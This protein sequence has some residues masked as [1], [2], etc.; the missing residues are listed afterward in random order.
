[1]D[2]IEDVAEQGV[3]LV[4]T[5]IFDA[6]GPGGLNWLLD[7]T[8]DMLV[9]RDDVV[10]AIDSE[11]NRVD[12][13]IK[14]GKPR[15]AIELPVDFDLGL[16][17]LNFEL[18]APVDL[19]FGFAF[20]LGFGVGVNEGF[21]L[22]VQDTGILVDF[23]AAVEDLNA[24]GELAF[25]NVD[26]TS[27]IDQQT[28]LPETRFTGQFE[29]GLVDPNSDNRLTLSEMLG[30][31]PSELIETTFSA[32]ADMNLQVVASIEG[33]DY[34]PRLR[35]DLVVD[36][37]F[38]AGQEVNLPSV[39]FENVQINLGD[40][41]SGFAGDV[42]NAVQDVLDPIQPMIE[43]LSARLPVISDLSGSTTTIIDLARTFG[44]ADVADFLD[45]IVEIN[46]LITGLPTDLGSNTWV[47]LGQF[48]VNADALGGFTGPGWS[49]SDTQSE[50]RTT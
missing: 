14:L 47:D 45:S 22:D 23:V 32:A 39:K 28:G 36:W 49:A 12:F 8:G 26:A 27:G 9:T 5:G 31:S 7:S 19:E 11:S 20:D 43:I 6:L 41:F 48:S 29:V 2:N 42:L 4:Q 17:G 37:D 44:R 46:D 21:F 3:S 35:T 10:A 24:S 33:S 25:L 34:L 15:Q 18:D 40:F 13:D 30:T 38:I 1:L 50:V 16:P